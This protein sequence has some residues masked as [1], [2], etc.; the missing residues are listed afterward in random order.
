VERTVLTIE[1]GQ[2]SDILRER[3][4]SLIPPGETVLSDDQLREL[5]RLLWQ[6]DQNYPLELEG[7]EREQVLLDFEFKVEPDGALAVKQVRP[8]LIPDTA[9]KS[10]TFTLEIPADTTLCGVFSEDRVG[11]LP[12][13]ELALKSTVRLREGLWDLPTAS[14]ALTADLIEEVRF[15]SEEAVA[16]A[17]G[18]GRFTF[19]RVPD[20]GSRTI[21]RFRYA[22]I[23]TVQNGETFEIRIENI[24]FTGRGDLD[25]TGPLALDDDYNTFDL[26][27][28]GDLMGIPRVGYSSCGSDLLP[29]FEIAVE[30]PDGARFRLEERFLAS[31]NNLGTGPGSL[32]RADIELAGE[33]QTITDYW[34][35]VYAA[36]RHNRNVQFWVV[37][38]PAIAIADLPGPVQVIEIRLPGPFDGTSA[39]VAYLD[40]SFAELR[41]FQNEKL[42]SFERQEVEVDR[43]AAFRRGD[44]DATGVLDLT[45][46][47]VLA[48]FLFAS[49]PEL[50]CEKAADVDDSGQLDLTDAVQLMTLLFLNARSPLEPF[51][52]CGAD[53]T[54]DALTCTGFSPCAEP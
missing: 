17:E 44:V 18:P 34:S 36:R 31:E 26:D 25:L 53:A 16:V 6:I 22:Q 46:G 24:N 33:Q 52:T 28:T 38:E 39:R 47:I 8:F 41:A 12:Q 30:L 2:V 9:P 48:N 42:R 29:H 11:R 51:E 20:T 13:T 3:S 10:P 40:A 49:G 1:D 50:S 54:E 23:F 35:L 45:D 19:V 32:V 27:M 5:G 21:Y 37:L 4:S 14:G 43:L 7:F 15:G